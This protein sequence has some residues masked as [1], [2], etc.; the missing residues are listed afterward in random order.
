MRHIRLSKTFER[1]LTDLLEFGEVHFGEDV[2]A[3]VKKCIEKT[4]RVFLA[5][6]PEAKAADVATQLRRHPVSRTP[7]IL[8]YDFTD[9]ELRIHFVFHK[10]ASLKNLDPKSATW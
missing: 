5:A 8:L 9:T 4:I 2:V 3:A 10:R 6:F 1:Q 7:F